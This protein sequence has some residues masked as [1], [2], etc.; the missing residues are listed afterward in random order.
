MKSRRK[1]T[2]PFIAFVLASTLLTGCGGGQPPDTDTGVRRGAR[3]AM[4]AFTESE[5]AFLNARPQAS[6]DQATYWDPGR[7]G[8]LNDMLGAA[9]A[10]HLQLAKWQQ[11][12]P[13]GGNAQYAETLLSE[14]T[15]DWNTLAQVARAEPAALDAQ[16][17]LLHNAMLHQD[18]LKSA[19]GGQSTLWLPPAWGVTRDATGTYADAPRPVASSSAPA[20]ASPAPAAAVATAAVAPAGPSFDDVHI[21]SRTR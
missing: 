1:I 9:Y 14:V 11:A 16:R 3:L 6:A 17:A 20:P 21:A 15:D 2:T 18:L 19:V 5:N 12:G 4:D 7:Q 10:L 13:D 8:P